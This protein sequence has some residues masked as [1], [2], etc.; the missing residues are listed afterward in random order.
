MA[1]T[2]NDNTGLEN[3]LHVMAIGVV[4]QCELIHISRRMGTPAYDRSYHSGHHRRLCLW[5]DRLHCAVPPQ[6]VACPS[7]AVGS[8]QAAPKVALRSQVINSAGVSGVPNR[9]RHDSG[10]PLKDRILG[11]TSPPGWRWRRCVSSQKDAHQACHWCACRIDNTYYCSVGCPP[12]YVII[13]HHPS[14][15]TSAKT[16]LVSAFDAPKV[17][18][19]VRRASRVLARKSWSVQ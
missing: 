12:G 19:P 6:R 13:P 14:T 1:G 7:A 9:R 4:A 8:H 17:P 15:I 2:T 10:D 11:T 16:L 5:A 18:L 3:G